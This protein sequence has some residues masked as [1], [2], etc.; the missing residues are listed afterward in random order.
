MLQSRMMRQE[1]KSF[2]W[3]KGLL[4]QETEKSGVV[5]HLENVAYHLKW[6]FCN[7]EKIVFTL[8]PL[9]TKISFGQQFVPYGSVAKNIYLKGELSFWFYTVAQPITANVNHKVLS[10]T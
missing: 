1:K 2:L 3:L 7:K 9:A 6:T 5:Q 8:K 4:H 10:T